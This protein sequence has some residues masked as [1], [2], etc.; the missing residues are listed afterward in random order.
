MTTFFSMSYILVLNGIIIRP[1]GI[2]PNAS[3]FSTGLASGLFT[4]MMGLCVNV[5]VALAPGMGLNGYFATV[6]KTCAANT[7]GDITKAECA[8][9][10][11]TALPWSDAMGAVFLSGF[12]YLFFTFTGLRTMLFRAVPISLRSAI[13]V[14]IGFFITIIG[15]KI[16]QITRV[17]VADFALNFGLLT[18]AA[19]CA[20]GSPDFVNQTCKPGDLNFSW[21]DLGIVN[22]NSNPDARIAVIGLIFV[23]G[24]EMLRVRGAIILAIIAATLIGINYTNCT[25]LDK[26]KLVSGDYAGSICVTDLHLWNRDPS[27]IPWIVDVTDITSGKLTFKYANTPIFWEAV[28]TF[29]FVE[30]FDSFGMI[31][32]YL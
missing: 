8:S 12:I 23:T 22:F 16:G 3:F 29:L 15:L 14:G 9:W 25:S 2:T 5:P 27:E 6:A 30:L 28:W 20:T 1:T 4:F 18:T 13:T 11:K 21:Y 26:A 24:L 31:F 32:L 19:D 10:G 17:T 7:N